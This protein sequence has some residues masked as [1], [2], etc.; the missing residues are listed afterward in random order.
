MKKFLFLVLLPFFLFLPKLAQAAICDVIIFDIEHTSELKEGSPVNVYVEVFNSGDL[1]G[2]V[3]ITFEGL[4]DNVYSKDEYFN[5]GDI[6]RIYFNNIVPNRHGYVEVKATAT[7]NCAPPADD[8]RIEVWYVLPAEFDFSIFLS[9]SSG[10]T[11][12]GGSVT[13]TVT[14][15]LTSGSTQSVSFSCTNLPSGASCSFSPPSCNPTCSSTLTI[16]TSSN[17]PPGTYSIT[18]KGTRESKTRFATFTLT[19]TSA[20]YSATFCQSG[21]PSSV[22]WGVEVNNVLYTT[23]TSCLTISGLSGT[24][25]YNY[26]SPVQGSQG[27]RYV[28]TSGCSGSISSSTTRTAYYKTQYQ[29]T[30]RVNPSNSGTTNPSVGSH[31]YDANSIVTISASPNPGYQ[32]SSWSGSGTGSYSG[33]ANPTTIQMNSPIIQTAN[34]APISTFDFSINLNPSSLTIQQGQSTSSTVIVNLISGIP[35]LVSLSVSGCP[36][37]SACSVNPSIGYPSFTSTLSISTSSTTPPGTY[38]ITV[39]GTS[40]NLVRSAVL[41]LT[42]T[43]QPPQCI[44]QN[45]T[46][47]I[48]PS[49]QSTTAGQTLVYTVSVTNN[50]NSACGSSIFNL[51]VVSCPPGFNCNLAINSLTIPPQS[52]SSTQIFVTSPTTA[53]SGTYIFSI[54]A[55]NTADI[56]KQGAGSANYVVLSLP[57]TFDFS[58]SLNPSSGI[59]TQGQGIQTI[60]NLN[61]ISGASQ[62]ISLS[63]ANLPPTTNCNFSLPSCSPTCSSL[64]TITTSSSTPIGS[65]N[66]LVLGSNGSIIKSSTFSLTIQPPPPGPFDFSISASPSSL[67]VHQGEIASST[68]TLTLISGTTRPVTFSIIAPSE[69]QA[70]ISPTS[71]NPTCSA[72]LTISTN[73]TTTPGN[74]LVLVVASGSTK[75]ISIPITVLEAVPFPITLQPIKAQPKQEIVYPIGFSAQ[76]IK[77]AEAITPTP[78]IEMVRVAVLPIPSLD[79]FTLLGIVILIILFFWLFIYR[80]K[81]RM[82]NEPEDP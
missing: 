48:S 24:V 31:W 66:I 35:Q 55:T 46:V 17:T 44:R 4:D 14:A 50:D 49:S 36:P 58:I 52:T 19:I 81:F 59:V 60:V 71:C 67:I 76:V 56:T 25:S 8:Q 39:F 79:I 27:I 9:P 29:L 42:V 26:Q 64:L 21:I 16:T 47:T 18:V 34:F 73:S 12:Q 78:P 13:S 3:H 38:S 20:T 72:V 32:F 80:K 15:T 75:T 57:P 7:I 41:T 5:P 63:C 33:S 6:K 54:R 40:G 37:S 10:T 74:Y 11:T 45:P 53:S 82:N 68:I 77:A 22:I 28:C 1:G 62:L 43:S 70:S 2:N 69:I 30:M 65:Y 23:S 61:L 51:A